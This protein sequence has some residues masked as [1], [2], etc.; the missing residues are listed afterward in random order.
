MRNAQG[1]S[2]IEVLISFSIMSIVFLA[3]AMS[4]VYGFRTTRD[5][6][7]ASTARDLASEQIEII[8][9]YGYTTYAKRTNPAYAG[10]PTISPS[11]SNDNVDAGFPDCSGS[12]DT[13][14]NFPG[15]TLAWEIAPSDGVSATDP[16]ALYDVEVTVERDDLTYTL[17]NYLSCADAGEFSVTGVSCPSNS[18]LMP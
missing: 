8:R 5:S 9:G 13:V 1:L 4:Q 3:L 7:E 11:G 17:S 12:D 18:L 15:Y 10:C 14:A 2:L 6:L 16:P